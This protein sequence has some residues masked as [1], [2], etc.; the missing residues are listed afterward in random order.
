MLN[1]GNTR[2]PTDKMGFVVFAFCFLLGLQCSLGDNL[3]I[4]AFNIQVFGIK[5]MEDHDVVDVL[6]KVSIFFMSLV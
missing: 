3:K 2:I 1:L 5:K 4:G 6:V